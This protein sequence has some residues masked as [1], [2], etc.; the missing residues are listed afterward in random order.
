MWQQV[1]EKYPEIR[2]KHCQIC[3]FSVAP[4]V[5]IID[6]ECHLGVLHNVPCYLELA[7]A[8]L[9]AVKISPCLPC[10]WMKWHL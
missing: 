3:M 9:M 10:D 8:S 2:E 7:S 6:S 4:Q 5:Y 1:L